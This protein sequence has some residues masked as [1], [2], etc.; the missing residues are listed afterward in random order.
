MEQMI[1]EIVYSDTMDVERSVN[2]TW[3]TNVNYGAPQQN[4]SLLSQ[5]YA[6]REL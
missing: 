4:P 6:Y 3:I 2:V 5:N 1:L